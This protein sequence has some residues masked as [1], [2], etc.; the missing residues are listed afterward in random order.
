[1]MVLTGNLKFKIMKKLFSVFIVA[2]VFLS[3]GFTN[4]NISA[5]PKVLEVFNQTFKNP[6]EVEWYSNE[7]EFTAT[8]IDNGIRTSITY[9]K[10]AVF[11]LSRRYYDERNLPFNIL[12]KIKQKY[13]DK[14]IGI[15]TEA[16][17]DDTVTYSINVEDEQQVYVVES[18][19]NANMKLHSKFKKQSEL[20]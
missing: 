5:S 9:D 15:V 17:E 2:S 4:R 12:L 10:N 13:K 1:M 3:F 18:D 7:N 8:F 14:K 19:G 6:K 20:K 11:L 16:I